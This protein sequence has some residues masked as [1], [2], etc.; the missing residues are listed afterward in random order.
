MDLIQ[1]ALADGIGTITLNNPARRNC[2]CAKL[3]GELVAALDSLERDGARAVVLRALPGSKVWSAGHDINELPVRGRDP[4][5]YEDALE[6]VLRKVQAIPLPVIALVEGSVWGGACDLVISCDIVV[7][8]QEATFAITPAKLGLPYNPSGLVHFINTVGPHKAKEMLYTARPISADDAVAARMVNHR[9]ATPAEAE[10]QAYTIARAI[11]DNAPL[12]VRV[13][14]RQFRML[15]AGSMLP[16]EIFEM[17]QGARRQVYESEDYMEGI[18]AF[19]EK[20]RP[21]FVG[22]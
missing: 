21:Q 16:A 5:D 7:C 22:R 10:E 1:V 17:L 19:K 6:T 9:A 20:R 2:I 15:L 11:A 14:K 18:R 13:L 4:L 12:A 3:V 8:S